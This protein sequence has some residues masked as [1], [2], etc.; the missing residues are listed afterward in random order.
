MARCV[1][2]S[3]EDVPGVL[4]RRVNQE[5]PAGV[6]DEQAP[7]AILAVAKLSDAELMSGTYLGWVFRGN[8][9]PWSPG[10]QPCV[11]RRDLV[12]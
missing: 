4:G 10:Y 7:E 5:N 1:R 3:R 8:P 11:A 6:V 12:Q 9:T 2:R